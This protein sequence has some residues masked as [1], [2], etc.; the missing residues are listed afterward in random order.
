MPIFAKSR[1]WEIMD[2]DVIWILLAIVGSIFSF[3]IEGRKKAARKRNVPD[4]GSL[5]PVEEPASPHRTGMRSRQIPEHRTKIS[6]PL[7]VPEP[8]M[9]MPVTEPEKKH[10]ELHPSGQAR[11]RFRVEDPAKMVIYSEIMRPKFMDD[12]SSL[13]SR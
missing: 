8:E 4:P 12:D 11:K 13:L 1:I 2:G 10:T 9:E 5:F 6:V 3:I 7:S